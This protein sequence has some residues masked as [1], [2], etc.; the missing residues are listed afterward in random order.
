MCKCT[1]IWI[2]LKINFSLLYNRRYSFSCKYAVVEN[3]YL[4][5][6]LVDK[7][8]LKKWILP[9]FHAAV[10]PKLR[11]GI[12]LKFWIRIDFTNVLHWSFFSQQSEFSFSPD[13]SIIMYQSLFHHFPVLLYE[14]MR[15]LHTVHIL[16]WLIYCLTKIDFYMNT[17]SL[18]TY[19]S[20]VDTF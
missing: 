11:T 18:I 8:C 17:G 20:K 13:C 7:I 16:V 12:A 5:L 9:K 4:E 1:Y 14:L 19:P 6:I 2:W 15:I 3:K 10:A